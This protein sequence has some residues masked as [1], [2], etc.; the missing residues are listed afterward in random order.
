MATRYPATSGPLAFVSA[1]QPDTPLRACPWTRTRACNALSPSRFALLGRVRM[2]SPT[3]LTRFTLE[4]LLCRGSSARRITGARARLCNTL[5]IS[6]IGTVATHALVHASG[7][8]SPGHVC[9]L[10]PR[11]VTIFRREPPIEVV[12]SV[13]R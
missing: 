10:S 1:T 3:A 5:I 11:E 2:S 7:T 9:R 6:V 12:S 13:F 8:V 4:R